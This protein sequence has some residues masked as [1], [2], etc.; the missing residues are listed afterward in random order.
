MTKI[1]L[2]NRIYSLGFQHFTPACPTWSDAFVYQFAAQV[3][4][5]LIRKKGVDLRY[6]ADFNNQ[7]FLN[8]NNKLSLNAGVIVHST[9]GVAK[10]NIHQLALDVATNFTFEKVD[11]N[12]FPQLPVPPI[13]ACA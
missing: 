11:S 4:V 7:I 5:V 8:E 9:Y 13:E 1:E 12:L 10:Y 2:Q 3:L 6:Y